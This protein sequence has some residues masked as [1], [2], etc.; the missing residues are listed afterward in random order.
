MVAENPQVL[1]DK[2]EQAIIALLKE[3]TVRRAAESIGIGERTLHRWLDD[4]EFSSA[5]RKARHIAFAHAIALTQQ[6][7]PVAIATLARVMSDARSPAASR[8]AAAMGLLKFSR[9][10]IELDDLAARVEALEQRDKVDDADRWKDG[11]A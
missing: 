9:D 8:V 7:T 10:S 5:Y 3:P 1:S 6:Y 2:Q 4:P 11:A